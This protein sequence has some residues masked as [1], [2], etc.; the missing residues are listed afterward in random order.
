VPIYVFRCP[1]CGRENEE[2]LRLGDVDPRPC[3]SQDCSGERRQK[4]SRVAVTYASFGFT[5][6]D[7]LV[8]NPE[9]KDYKA[10]KAKAQEIADS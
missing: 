3:L 6:T 2:L 4:L 10:L 9:T 5:T 7:N 8:R 1:V